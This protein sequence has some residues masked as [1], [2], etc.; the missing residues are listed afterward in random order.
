MRAD[1]YLSNTLDTPEKWPALLM[2]SGDQ[3][4]A[5][6]VAAPMLVAIHRLLDKLQLPHEVLEEADVVDT[7]ALCAEGALYYRREELLPKTRA[8]SE[9]RELLFGGVRKPVFTSDNAHNYLISKGK[10]LAMYLLVW[11]PQGWKDIDLEAPH[12]L[13]SEYL[14]Q[15]QQDSRLG[16]LATR[17][18][19]YIRALET[20]TLHTRR[21]TV[22]NLVGLVQLNR[23]GKFGHQ[24]PHTLDRYRSDCASHLGA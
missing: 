12:S 19:L 1:S 7:Q 6:D 2:L 4:Y 21:R 24:Y 8:C 10:V 14:A 5:D 15:Y 17:I 16:R 13:S 3:V 9:L 22:L 18:L 20:R 23:A 11:S